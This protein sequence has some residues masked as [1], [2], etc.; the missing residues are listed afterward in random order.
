MILSATIQMK[1]TL[2]KFIDYEN[3]TDKTPLINQPTVVI[4]DIEDNL[5]VCTPV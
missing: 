1:N 2:I 5:S 4:R 3:C